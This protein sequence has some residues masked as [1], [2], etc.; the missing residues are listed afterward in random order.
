MDKLKALLKQ[1]L[2]KQ[3]IQFRK[4]IILNPTEN[5]P[6]SDDIVHGAS[7][8]H[9]LYNTD[10]I[11]NENGQKEKKT[12]FAGRNEL[13]KDINYIYEIW[14]EKLSAGA[15]S[16]R[17]LSGLNAHSTFFMS[18]S[19]VGDNIL[20]LPEVAGGHTSL[21]PILER[22]GLNV[23]EMFPDYENHRIDIEKTINEFSNIKF[24]YLLIDRSEG[25]IFED[26]SSLL[27]EYECTKIFDASQYLSNILSGDYPNPLE[28]GYDFLI[29]SIHKNFP[30]PQKALIASK[31]ANSEWE[32]VKAGIS[33]YVSNMHVHNI[34]SAGYAIERTEW[35]KKYSS[36]LL[37]NAL[38]LEDYLSKEG[39]NVV[40]RPI[41]ELP[42]HHLW[43]K[44]SSKDEAYKIYMNFEK[45]GINTNYRLLPYKLGMGLRLGV[46]A[47]SR[48]SIQKD[49][50]YL[51]SKIITDIISN[52][53]TQKTKKKVEEI[54]NK[55]WDRRL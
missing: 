18:H 7:F 14:R 27:K 28:N 35:L 50:L 10:S 36:S 33:T 41:E 3:E 55:L 20:I 12:L 49:E 51:L 26:F 45:C 39:V 1:S 30:G 17:L 43:L 24:K 54:A 46:S 38:L 31:K 16:L 42:T 53:A 37:K 40:K 5:I 4:S 47:I 13:V 21:K 9:G 48:L 6:F 23:F 34:Y 32:K 29:S 25:L 22:L 44:C 19:K 8:L 15:I 11:R 52:G 2:K